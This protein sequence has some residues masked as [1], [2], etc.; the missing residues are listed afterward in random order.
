MLEIAIKKLNSRAIIPKKMSD[1]AA[2]Y[3]IYS[4]NDENITLKKG[5]VTSIPTGIAISLPK[6]YEGQIRPRS[7]LA[8]KHYITI[9]NSPGTIDSD[10][11][12]EIKIILFNAGKDEFVVEPGMR[13]AQ[14]VVAKYAELEF[15]LTENLDNTKRG[16][17]GFGHTSL[18]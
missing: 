12:G 11:R 18:K 13:I 10:Y 7:G 9:L 16:V 1:Y 6:G 15:K 4:A 14:L 17:N 5:E 3:D 8:L 2:G